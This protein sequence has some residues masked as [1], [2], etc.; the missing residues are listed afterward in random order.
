MKST[1]TTII[2]ILIFFYIAYSFY[3]K[4]EEYID[5]SFC[6]IHK[7]HNSG[8]STKSTWKALLKNNKKTEF[9]IQKRSDL[10]STVR[11]VN[12]QGDCLSTKDAMTTS[13]VSCGDPE[14]LKDFNQISEN[15]FSLNGKCLSLTNNKFSFYE[16][17]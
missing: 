4:K 9:T 16:C 3:F 17:K 5:S 15:E 14:F 6:S 12:K 2:S 7:G 10:E 8:N 1:I 11:I 13:W